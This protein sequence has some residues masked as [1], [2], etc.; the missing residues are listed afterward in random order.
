MRTGQPKYQRFENDLR[1][2][3]KYSANMKA[4]DDANKKSVTKVAGRSMGMDSETMQ[5]LTPSKLQSHLDSLSSQ[6]QKLEADSVGKIN[7]SEM[8]ELAKG[9]SN[10]PKKEQNA[11]K[12]Q[13]NKIIAMKQVGGKDSKGRFTAHTFDGKEYQ[14]TRISLKDAV[15]TAFSKGNMASYRTLKDMV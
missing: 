14:K 5:D 2:D 11:V 12:E 8:I 4:F 1:S 15:N 9:I 13:M 6:Y 7:K 3:D 10:L